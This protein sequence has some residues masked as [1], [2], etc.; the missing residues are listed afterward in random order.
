M[1]GSCEPDTGLCAPS[2]VVDPA[3]LPTYTPGDQ[4]RL[5]GGVAA[6][7]ETDT[8]AQEGTVPDASEETPSAADADAMLPGDGSHGGG[9]APGC[10]ANRGTCDGSTQAND[11]AV[12]VSATDA[13]ADVPAYF[14]PGIQCGSGYCPA[15][16]EV[17]CWDVLASGAKTCLT[18]A[19]QMAGGCPASY[20][21][22]IACDDTLD[23]EAAGHPGT[24]CCQDGAGDQTCMSVAACKAVQFSAVVCDPFAP[25]P[26]PSGARCG[27]PDGGY[28]VV[29]IGL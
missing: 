7:A 23:C 6:D 17:C 11:A 1:N 19:A 15:G 26:C 28:G 29:C 22:V 2:I 8:G 3:T 5:D 9:D 4:N 16:L 14:D 18:T 21:A 10:T 27:A 13:A 20:S 24:V 25:V 12:D